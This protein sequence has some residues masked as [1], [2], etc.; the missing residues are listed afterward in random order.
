MTSTPEDSSG[1]HGVRARVRR[2]GVRAGYDLWSRTYDATDNPMV[3][4]ERRHSMV[5]LAPARGERILDA[6]CG[7]GGHLAGL[8]AR[9]A[10]AVGIDFSFGM[11]EVARRAAPDAR[12]LQADLNRPLP[13][14]RGAFDAVLAALV[15]EH[16]TALEG[17]CAEAF[18][19]LRAGGRLVFSAFHPDLAHAGVEANFELDG[20]EYRLG[21][22][23]HTTADYLDSMRGA[24]F[25][26]VR[27]RTLNGDAELASA[28]PAAAKYL[29]RPMLLLIEARRL[30][31]A[32]GI[33][34]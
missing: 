27:C 18:A 21:A 16:L 20:V 30:S 17:F 9:G 28:V 7:T 10:Q 19:V 4:L 26:E 24:G 22:E 12:L 25:E 1:R 14:R 8:C 5:A 32:S 23:G 34:S 3:A 6:G 29:H 15:S 13:L 2:P 33:G 31:R 11:L